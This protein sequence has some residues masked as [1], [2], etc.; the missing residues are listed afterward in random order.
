MLSSTLEA[1]EW[2]EVIDAADGDDPFD[3]TADVIYRRSLRRSKMTREYHCDPYNNML[4]QTTCPGA[5]QEGQILHV[6]ELR[7]QRISHEMV[8]RLHFGLWKDLE[9][10]IEIPIM[11]RDEQNLRYAGD[12][13][14]ARGVPVT[15]EISSIVPEMGQQQLLSFSGLPVRSGFG[16]MLFK[17]RFAPISFE[18]DDARG[19]WV[20]ELGY[21]APTGEIMEYGNTGIG[22][23]VH[24]L[25]LSTAFSRQF[26]YV[27]PYARI[28]FN[29]PF[30]GA[31]KS[32]FQE[33]Y[34]SQEYVLPG[35]RGSFDFGLEFIPYYNP[36]KGIKFFIDLGLGASYQAEGRNY[37]ELFDALAQGARTCNRND[38][39]RNGKENC[40]YYNEDAKNQ[41]Q[42][43]AY[44][45]DIYDGITTVEEFIT[46]RGR[47]GF[48][49][50]ASDHFRIG[51]TLSLAHATEHHISS[52]EIGKDLNQDGVFVPARTPAES[53]EHNPT[54]VPSIDYVG[55]RIRVEETTIFTFGMNMSLLF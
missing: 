47:L 52:G 37:S 5:P 34:G 51:T 53:A 32:L 33:Y 49:I 31:P 16:D 11:L 19:E 3:F 20:L 10:M 13:G 39:A 28:S 48:G 30:A 22:R 38:T 23:G 18:R 42:S 2:T 44:T 9:L 26:R 36:L 25:E 54:F 40:A 35:A 41:N 12:G 7:Y 8:P 27:E 29:L 15:A 1:V 55:R 45:P 24:E 46:I 6:K 50:Y 21:R 4:D 17:L 43:N 14:E